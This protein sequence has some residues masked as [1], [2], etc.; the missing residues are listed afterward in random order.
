MV[1]E[2]T[3]LLRSLAVV[4]YR[5]RQDIAR[6]TVPRRSIDNRATDNVQEADA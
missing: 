5:L 1:Q 4:G 2:Q 6:T 3:N